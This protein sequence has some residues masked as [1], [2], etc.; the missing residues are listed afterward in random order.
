MKNLEGGT[1]MVFKENK[2]INKGI[3]MVTAFVVSIALA[4]CS[5]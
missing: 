2:F 1:N 5:L 3:K 4:G